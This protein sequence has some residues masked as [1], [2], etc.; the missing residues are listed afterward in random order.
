MRNKANSS[1]TLSQ[2]ISI[3]ESRL[4]VGWTVSITEEAYS[5]DRYR[6]D[7]V[8]QICSPSRSCGF[9]LIK[10]KNRL[11][12][13]QIADWEPRLIKA[14]TDLNATG[15]LII[16]RYLSPMARNR[17]KDSRVSYIDLT[18][19]T[20]IVV[21]RPAVYVETQGQDKDPNPN[22]RPVKTLKGA[23]AARIVRAL[24]DWWPPVGVRSLARRAGA[25]PG[26]TSKVLKFLEDEDVIRRDSMGEVVEVK[27]RDLLKRWAQDYELTETNPTFGYLA[28]RGLDVFVAALREYSGKWALTGSLAVPPKVSS[29]PARLATC[30]IED[31]NSAAKELGL[32]QTQ[33][34][35]NV[36]LLEPF[37]TVVWERTRR[38]RGLSCVAISQCA[39][40]LLTGTGRQPA[41][42]E[43]LLTW[44]A[45]NE[46][47]W[48][49]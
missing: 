20:R 49:T 39:V 38:E 36:L 33:S 9:L 7:A 27:W 32:R 41:E 21:D 28:P 14:T 22:P 43:D 46:N 26:Y 24:C 6:P 16:A 17:L 23:K 1:N 37:D 3:L 11:T 42:A 15:V 18:G 2:A 48:R 4:P 47:V 45:G 40:D 29:A 5:E 8:L 30:Y 44:M 34:G 25:D 13:K 19:N 10:V 31:P 35:T 12:A